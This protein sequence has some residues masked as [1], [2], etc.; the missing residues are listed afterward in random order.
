MA[1]YSICP[2]NVILACPESFTPLW[3]RGGKG[4]F[5]ENLLIHKIPLNPPLPKGENIRKDSL[6]VVDPTSGNDNWFS[7]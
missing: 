6:R 4:D 3:K 2:E 7:I 1:G 5:M